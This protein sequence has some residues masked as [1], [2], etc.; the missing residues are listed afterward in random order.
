MPNRINFY[1]LIKDLIE[2]FPHLQSRINVSDEKKR[3]DKCTIHQMILTHGQ[4]HHFIKQFWNYQHFNSVSRLLKRHKKFIEQYTHQSWL[5]ILKLIKKKTKIN[6]STKQEN[7]SSIK[8][9]RRNRKVKSSKTKITSKP[10]FPLGVQYIF[11]TIGAGPSRKPINGR[12]RSSPCKPIK[13]PFSSIS[14]PR[15]LFSNTEHTK[16]TVLLSN[17]RSNKNRMGIPIVTTIQS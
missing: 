2:C 14:V 8:C 7:K 13:T 16:P 3:K 11:S 6:K 5:F 12:V 4:L 9:G 15:S 17:T 1:L 10:F